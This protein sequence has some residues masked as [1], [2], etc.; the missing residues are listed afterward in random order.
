MEAWT[1][2][3]APEGTREG[4]IP[5]EIVSGWTVPEVQPLTEARMMPAADLKEIEIQ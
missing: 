3:S 5:R 2:P 1:L 4:L